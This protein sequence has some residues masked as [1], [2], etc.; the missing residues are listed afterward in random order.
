MPDRYGDH[1]DDGP[2]YSMS[3]FTLGEK[4]TS[5]VYEAAEHYRRQAIDECGLC[6]GDGQRNGFPCDH[7]DHRPAA[8]RGMAKIREAMGWNR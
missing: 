1:P 8:A 2:A 4:D 6:D 3:D 7:T 5:A